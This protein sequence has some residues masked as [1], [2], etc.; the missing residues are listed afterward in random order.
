IRGRSVTLAFPGEWPRVSITI[1]VY[2]EVAQ[3]D[4][5]LESILR[6]DYPRDRL[7]ILVVSDASDDGTDERVAAYA[8]RGVALLRMPERC[9][10]SAAENAAR[11]HLRGDIIVN[12]DA[13]I[14]IAPDA[15]KPLITRFADPSVGL[16]SGRDVSVTRVTDELNGGESAYVGYEMWVRSIETEVAGIVGASG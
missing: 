9:G 7:Q 6:I 10:K 16:A 2:N 12:T 13:S 5:L 11:S 3:I 15:L 14:R 8:A 4:E 1:P